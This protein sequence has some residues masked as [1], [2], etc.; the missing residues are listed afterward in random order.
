MDWKSLFFNIRGRI[1]RSTFWLGMLVLVA[2]YWGT[3]FVLAFMDAPA[4]PEVFWRERYVPLF[5]WGVLLFFGDIAIVIKRLHDLD[6][7]GRWILFK[8]LPLVNLLF[9]L[10]LGVQKGTSGPNR[11]GP[12]PLVDARVF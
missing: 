2:L 1:S 12:E 11:F 4:T 10:M 6:M 5:I 9:Y 3:V 7:S 8:F